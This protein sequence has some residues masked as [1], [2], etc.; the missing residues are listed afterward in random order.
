MKDPSG[1]V[2]DYNRS[3]KPLLNVDMGDTPWY[4]RWYFLVSW[5]PNITLDDTLFA[6]AWRSHL[7]SSSIFL[8]S[9]Y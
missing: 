8:L 3:L 7:W 4:P 1:Y 9:L 6:P 5:Y 2:E